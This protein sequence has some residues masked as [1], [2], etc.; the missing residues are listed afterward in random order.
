[1]YLL[2]DPPLRL[3]VE[4]VGFEQRGA[5]ALLRLRLL[6]ASCLLA[7]EA[8]HALHVPQQHRLHAL[9][10]VRQRHGVAPQRSLESGRV[11]G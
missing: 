7:Q 3:G 8:L 6:L 1:V 2:L 10:H 9:V 5:P 4:R 11:L